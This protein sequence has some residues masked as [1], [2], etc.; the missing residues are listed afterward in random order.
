[1]DA[2]LAFLF[3]YP[4]RVWERGDL[5]WSPVLPPWVVG[6]LA[7]GAAVVAGASYARVRGLR[8]LDRGTLLAVR[9]ATLLLLVA[10]LL[11]PTLVVASAVPQR[12]LLAILLDD[13]RSMRIADTRDTT[14]AAAVERAFAD[15]SALVR[16]LG[17]RF[18]LRFYRF[19]ADVRP[20]S[21][22]SGLRAT[23]TRT[24]VA[25][26]LAGVREE[27]A[28]APLAGVILVSDG[29][30]NG[31]RD[32]DPA[33]L[34][35]RTRRVPVHTVGVGLERFPRDVAIERIAV[36]SR[37][38][39][40]AHL[41]VD[42]T[43]RLRGVG[44]ERLVLAAESDGRV[45]AT[46]TITL[47]R[48]EEIARTRLRLPELAPGT[49]RVT[50]RAAALAR[51]TVT[52]NNEAHALVQVRAGPDRIL[53]L[54]G[55]PRP[56]IAFLRRA[57]ATDS[58]LQLVTLLRSAEKKYLRLGVRDSL[59]LAGGFPT[60]RA[61]LFAFRG[62]I[63]GSIEAS[64]FTPDQL[65]MIGD[66]VSQRGGGL[67]ALG[68][69]STLAEGG[70]RGTPVAEVLPVALDRA[71]LTAEGPATELHLRPTVAGR[72]QAALQLAATDAASARK[73][74]S[75]PP[76]T[77]VN[78]LGS[79][80]PG[81][82]AWLT[83]RREG[84]TEDRPVLATQRFGRGTATLFG[85]QDTWLWRMH[86]R[87]A[88]EDRTHE[89][90][91]RQLARALTEEAPDRVE[92]AAVPMRVAPGEPVTLRARVA[93]DRY[94][95]VNDAEVTARVTAP[96]GREVTV[97]LEWALAE[98]GV[99]VGRYIA[100]EAGVY[101]ITADARRGRDTTRA[102]P[103]ALLADDHGADVEQAELRTP[104]L[105]RIA[106]QTG[107]RY[108]PLA[109]VERLADDVQ[110]TESGVTVREARDLWDMPVVFLVLAG[111]LAT[112]WG[113]RRARGLA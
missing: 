91:W 97:P 66:F 46:D 55:E 38:L 26:A 6:A 18:A 74:D 33:L 64:F 50:V 79:L 22:A 58:A 57:V 23:G 68:G 78:A 96:S 21:G 87:I 15:S 42:V 5:V 105:R 41:L 7:V 25:T 16:A 112:E 108:Y 110:Y 53:Y 70:Y 24:D 32:L 2:V 44:G 51:E 31:G 17:E 76:L 43:L 48:N 113:L 69:R 81:A 9:A 67:L 45:V 111:L 71:P 34:G 59:E 84:E 95:D 63:L 37:P 20:A 104:L 40:G 100:E 86:A 19:A 82:T 77:V 4:A 1:M 107:G 52:E 75:L 27:L 65:R 56:E 36:P 61:E 14:R 35:L 47:P 28:G 73:W 54:E 93:D 109:D 83:G 11:R 3:K 29:A 39:A 8:P 49:H 99:Y 88:V 90:L 10:L 92:V 103:G 12:N 60:N 98:D 30:D 62:L 85:V 106:Q 89:T 80:R 94:L 72:E 101:A 13:S 102:A